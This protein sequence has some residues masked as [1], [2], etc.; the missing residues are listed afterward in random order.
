MTPRSVKGIL[1]F[2]VGAALVAATVPAPPASASAEWQPAQLSGVAA[3]SYLLSVSCP[4]LSLCVASGTNNL[5]ASSTNPVAGS[6]SWS[7]AFV[8]EGPW[9]NSANWPSQE[10]SGLQIESIS[11]PSTQL[12]VAVMNKG[13]IY[14][15]TNPTGPASAWKTVEID[16][17]GGRNTHLKGISC[18]S[19]TLCVAVSERRIGGGGGAGEI[20][21]NLGKVLVSTNP[22]G[23]A[24]DWRVSDAPDGTNFGAV[25]CPRVDFCVA[26][27][28]EG[29][30]VI[31]TEPTGGAG[32]WRTVGAPVG[33]SAL[34]AIGCASS[35]LCVA[36]N[37]SGTLLT[38]VDPRGG[39]G[40]WR[41][42]NGGGSV[43]VTG[44]NCP[45]PSAC[46]VVDNNG[47]VATSTDPTGGSSA[48]NYLNLIQ[49]ELPQGGSLQEGN[50]LF[51]AACVS[52]SFCVVAGAR[53]Q[54]FT[55][56][57][58]FEE[59]AAPVGKKTGRKR[60]AKRPKA[61]IATLRLFTR[62]VQ[63]TH[64][65][66][67][68][69]FFAR[70][71]NS[72][73]ACKIDK[74]RYRRCHSPKRFHLDRGRHVFRVRAIGVTGKRGPA[75]SAVIH[76]GGCRTVGRHKTCGTFVEK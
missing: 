35:A 12:C 70:G 51:G 76:V 45:S 63:A 50:G 21:A 68:A 10:I 64:V 52:R 6:S 8:G 7:P 61:K 23:A 47:S 71:G 55:S 16:D 67:L 34:Q 69:R 31:S 46:L 73:F 58:A 57:N 17:P 60:G 14:S 66:A 30:I 44:A 62:S 13:L 42:F 38:S 41:S 19:V 54:L 9:Q 65:R 3:K 29:N 1:G 59:P 37:K 24:T 22:T 39:I 75:D 36:G 49:Y 5:I 40:T 2:L 20:D 72:G 15:T 18:P 26:V 11:C 28:Q 25:T 4:S 27:G 74:G 33:Q 43:Q 56:T 48:W 32:A 53:G